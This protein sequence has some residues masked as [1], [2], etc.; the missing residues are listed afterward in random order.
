MA[1][2]TS[3]AAHG[4]AARRVAPRRLLVSLLVML[5][6]AGC[7]EPYVLDGGT[8]EAPTATPGAV[9]LLQRF[10]DGKGAQA[11]VGV[12]NP[13]L[14]G[15]HGEAAVCLRSSP[16]G[17]VLMP[18]VGTGGCAEKDVTLRSCGDAE[19]RI[20]SVAFVGKTPLELVGVPE[21]TVIQPGGSVSARVRACPLL[22]GP[23]VGTIQIGVDGGA[24][25]LL[26]VHGEASVG[27]IVP[28]L[29]LPA[30]AWTDAPVDVDI[31]GSHS[32][33]GAA[34]GARWSLLP[35]DDWAP[36]PVVADGPTAQFVPEVAGTW[37]VCADVSDG[38][39]TA[40][41]APVCSDLEVTPDTD[42]RVELLWRTPGAPNPADAG[43]GGAADLDLHLALDP[44]G[45]AGRGSSASV[46]TAPFFDSTW[47]LWSKRSEAPW[48]SPSVDDDGVLRRA[49]AGEGA[50]EVA[51]VQTPHGTSMA[52][53]AY[54]I[55][56]HGWNDH[57]FGT[58]QARLRI[59]LEGTLVASL[60][61]E[62]V[63][64]L[65]LWTAAWVQWPN[66]LHGA[67]SQA[68]QICA[69]SGQDQARGGA[70]GDA[71]VTPCAVPT[72]GANLGHAPLAACK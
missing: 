26:S 53:I 11:V 13:T 21:G 1:R 34:I 69:D 42:L 18:G 7:F 41:C 2:P 47:D 4:P 67:T 66:T 40:A 35:P 48:G 39:G 22:A 32:P 36:I 31:L 33:T 6:V 24:P 12:N 9:G 54:R 43:P 52:P 70:L 60:G 51:T 5:L 3:A 23:Y 59:W 50:L 62:A 55:G 63:A 29:S 56:V 58:S 27:C 19:V 72:G 65:S 45:G 15:P 37:R 44:A 38:D 61:S 68:L 28:Q 64:P 25:V 17:A 49:D 16:A 20:A 8:R 10:D 46:T 30:S 14:G 57:G 71:C